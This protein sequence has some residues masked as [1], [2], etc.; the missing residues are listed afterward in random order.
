MPGGGNSRVAA[1][2]PMWDT[3]ATRRQGICGVQ[4]QGPGAADDA[5]QVWQLTSETRHGMLVHQL[6][7]GSAEQQS[8]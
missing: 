7:Y 3:A 2:C 6:L 5:K 4:C 8:N 1:L